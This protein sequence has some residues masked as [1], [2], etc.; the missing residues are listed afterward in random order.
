MTEYFQK[1]PLTLDTS[2]INTDFFTLRLHKAYKSWQKYGVAYRKNNEFTAA[3]N[4]SRYLDPADAEF[5]LRQLPQE[6][7]RLE[8]PEVWMLYAE[9]VV[10]E[11]RI[12]F[13][14][15]VDLVRLSSINIY[16]K[17]NGEKTSYFEYAPGGDILE[18]AS[19]TAQDGDVYLLNSNKPHSVEMISGAS[20]TSISVSFIETPYEVV[21]EVLHSTYSAGVHNDYS[22]KMVAA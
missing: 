5:I 8:V 22:R 16:F 1:L 21:Q 6:L 17:T 4:E 18:V 9:P 13:P 7:S 15:H 3:T 20:R 2:G 19:F 11:G 10:S 12:V 14:P